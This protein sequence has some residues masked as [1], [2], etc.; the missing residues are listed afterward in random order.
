MDLGPGGVLQSSRLERVGRMR[1]PAKAVFR[2]EFEFDRS[3][4][5]VRLLFFFEE[6]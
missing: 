3:W 1:R 4:P 6:L 5:K 2:F